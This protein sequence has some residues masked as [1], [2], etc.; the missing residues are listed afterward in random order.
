MQRIG[1]RLVEVRRASGLGVRGFAAA[2]TR[3]TGYEISHTSVANYESGTTV[4]AV[5]AVA[6]SRTFAVG[7]PWLLTGEGLPSEV[8]QP[9]LENA[10]RR[11]AA[12]VSEALPGMR[13]VEADQDAFFR[14]SPDLF[15]ILDQNGEIVRANPAWEAVLGRPV[16]ELERTPFSAIVHEESRAMLGKLLT[17]DASGPVSA[18][19]R[20]KSPGRDWLPITLRVSHVGGLAYGVGRWSPAG[21]EESSWLHI[22]QDVLQDASDLYVLFDDGARC[23]AV[24]RAA[25]QA[26]RVAPASIVGKSMIDAIIQPADRERARVVLAQF[27]DAGH[28]EREF[29]LP[30]EGRSPVRL[31]G[32]L[33]ANVEPGVHLGVA[34]A[35]QAQASVATRLGAVGDS[36]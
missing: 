25:A 16:R 19:L 7:L 30:G 29:M 36:S 26:L 17:F 5:Y 1:E 13:G 2:I 11:I 31:H 9:E 14:S 8:G 33:V 28:L 32:R 6:V 12:I 34:H 18:E 21:R 27:L 23:L 3:A 35:R 22:V 4:P 10:F 20:V 15:V 24:N